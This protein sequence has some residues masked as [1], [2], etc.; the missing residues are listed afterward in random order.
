[1]LFARD[2]FNQHNCYKVCLYRV[3][4]Q[5]QDQLKEVLLNRE[6]FPA[7]ITSLIIDGFNARK[8][9]WLRKYPAN[10]EGTQIEAFTCS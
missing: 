1:M 10:F 6:H 7:D 9:S 3:P 4:S 8:S 2:I 5:T